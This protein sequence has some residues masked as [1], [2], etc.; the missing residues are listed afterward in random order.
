MFR[1]RLSA[2]LTPLFATAVALAAA[3][4]TAAEATAVDFTGAVALDNCSGSLVRTPG[5]A[6]TDPAL[7]LSNGHC[8]E[9]GMPGPGEV[10]VD[11]P[12]TRTFDLLAADGSASLGTLTAD[13]LV[14]A[15]MTGTD[16]SM[17]R[18]NTS[19]AEIEQRYGITAPELADAA[20]ATG[21]EISVVSGYWKTIYS[22]A[23]D[24]EVHEL[25]EA[26]W[27]WTDAIRYTADCDT[28]HGSSGS[29]VVDAGTGK[30]VGVNNT[31]N[32]DGAECTMNNPCEVDEA[33]NRTVH[34]GI[35]Y[36]QQTHLFTD[37]L[38]AGSGID[39]ARP[40]CALAKPSAS[41]LPDAA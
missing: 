11:V 8:I 28:P 30:V 10:L 1:R 7:V 29:P 41:A 13:S 19:Y 3:P 40:E 38:T 31:G 2:V 20:P 17:Y 37:C 35:G 5:A 39:L 18:L 27:V 12:S 24:A 33:G 34:Q 15:T 36:G 22:C 16:A 21:T 9:Q 6:P 32:D 26:D 25:H 14:Y 4:A 23:M